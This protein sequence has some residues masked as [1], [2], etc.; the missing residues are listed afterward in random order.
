MIN[1]LNSLKHFLTE[2]VPLVMGEWK[3]SHGAQSA[4]QKL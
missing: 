1:I 2:T 3:H 4:Q